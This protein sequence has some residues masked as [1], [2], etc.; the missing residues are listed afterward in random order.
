MKGGVNTPRTPRYT[1]RRKPSPNYTNRP[2][3]EHSPIRN[4]P[5]NMH[6]LRTP[7]TPSIPRDHN[8]YSPLRNTYREAPYKESPPRRDFPREH[9][10]RPPNQWGDMEG[11]DHK[12]G[13]APQGATTGA[14]QETQTGVPQET[15]ASI[16]HWQPPRPMH[17]NH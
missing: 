1:Q 11:Q 3:Q 15:E 12:E 14:P 6:T 5:P 9:R 8:R 7:R 13:G 2:Q 4:R 16:I 10:D 17:T